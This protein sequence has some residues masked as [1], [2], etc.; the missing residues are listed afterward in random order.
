VLVLESAVYPA[1]FGSIGFLASFVFFITHSHVS[2]STNPAKSTNPGKIP[3]LMYAPRAAKRSV[4]FLLVC[5]G[6]CYAIC[7]PWLVRT[8]LAP[9]PAV[10]G[11]LLGLAKV[12]PEPLF[13]LAVGFLPVPL[14]WLIKIT[15]I[16]EW[17]PDSIR[18]PLI[19]LAD[20][21]I[22]RWLAT[23][24]EVERD[25]TN[26]YLEYRYRCAI[27]KVFAFHT[28]EVAAYFYCR[29]SDPER[30]LSLPRTTQRDVKFGALLQFFGCRRCR[31]EINAVQEDKTQGL[32]PTWFDKS[33]NESTERR[34][35]NG[36]GSR[37][38]TDMPYVEDFIRRGLKRIEFGVRP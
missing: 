34:S 37:R 24:P 7:S 18:K 6:A 27:D 25:V 20:H 12:V 5:L 1:L 15:G 16:R 2:P 35:G 3:F 4:P 36:R 17:A 11:W 31:V 26:N 19:W 22:N 38:R 30:A 9:F 21:T 33:E 28:V 29:Y 23:I 14:I 32:F 8:I 13:C 10:R